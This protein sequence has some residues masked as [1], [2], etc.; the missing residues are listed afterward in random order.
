MNIPDPPKSC[1]IQTKSE[2]NGIT[3]FWKKPSGGA[4]RYFVI[5]FLAFWLCGWFAGLVAVGRQLL[6][7]KGP[8]AF[9]AAWLAGWIVGGIFAGVM[10]YLLLRPQKPESVTLEPDRFRYDTGSAPPPRS[11]TLSRPTWMLALRE[12]LLHFL[13]WPSHA[14]SNQRMPYRSPISCKTS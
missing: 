3:L 1:Q 12:Q 13:S 11:V 9:L 6:T 4:S 14:P 7:E 10:L 8:N 5:L 2:L